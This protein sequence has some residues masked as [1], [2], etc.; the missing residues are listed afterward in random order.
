MLVMSGKPPINRDLVS[1]RP[2]ICNDWLV[3][4]S[5][6]KQSVVL[7]VAFNL[8]TEDTYVQYFESQEAAADFVT[9]LVGEIE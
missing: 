9:R 5:A 1:L 8:F 2:V 6:Y 4:A 7:V 3:K